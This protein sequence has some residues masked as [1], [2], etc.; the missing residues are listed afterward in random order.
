MFKPKKTKLDF[1]QV[2][3]KIV[4]MNNHGGK[5]QGSGRKKK[6]ISGTQNTITIK[7][8]E[9]T[10]IKYSLL[11]K[12]ENRLG[13][14]TDRTTF[15]ADLIN[16]EYERQLK[17]FERRKNNFFEII[18]FIVYSFADFFITE[19]KRI[20]PDYKDFFNKNWVDYL[21]ESNQKYKNM[22]NKISSFDNY[23]KH[24]PDSNNIKIEIEKLYKYEKKELK[25][26]IKEIEKEN[27][28]LLTEST[29]FLY[30]FNNYKIFL[31]KIRKTSIYDD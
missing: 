27:L 12:M 16:S 3:Y 28:N 18:N 2:L 4:S 31:D 25:R 22:A 14:K 26:I 1:F 29:D 6:D 30:W 15:F 11:V 23:L 13:N 5:R 9:E 7:V 10:K 20:I 21:Y 19:L 17:E 24:H 8:N